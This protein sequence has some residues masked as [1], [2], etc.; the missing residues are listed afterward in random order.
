MTSSTSVTIVLSRAGAKEGEKMEFR[1]LGR[2]VKHAWLILAG[3]LV[4]V[5]LARTRF[6]FGSML[7]RYADANSYTAGNFEYRAK[8][9][10][11]VEINWF[12]A[13]VTVKQSSAGT[14]SV[15]ESDRGLNEKQKLHWRLEDGKLV[16]QYCQSGYHGRFPSGA[17][18]LTIEVPE[19][20]QL[21]IDCVSSDV[22]LAG[23]QTYDKVTV[24]SVSGNVAFDE[25][26]ADKVDVDTVSGDI[27]GGKLS[28]DKAELKTT[29]G[30]ITIDPVKIYKIS[31][32]T[33][34]GDVHLLSLPDDSA[35]IQFSHV[36]GSL[37]TQ[38]EYKKDAN[39][40]IFGNGNNKIDVDTVS[41]DLSL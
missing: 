20:I 34:S 21:D 29:S 7:H 4:T 41:G 19:G 26:A 32:G 13:D 14:L 31:I 24:N 40:Y 37:K 15:A 35:Q 22:K 18:D 16:I 10:S 3:V 39:Q 5:L 23:S 8:D 11:Q 33:V 17:K 36:S 25:I 1:I 9:V 30:N 12:S 28:S 27:N 2:T 6:S 38:R